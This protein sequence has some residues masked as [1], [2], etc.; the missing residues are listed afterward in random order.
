MKR[1]SLLLCFFVCATLCQAQSILGKWITYD[2]NTK[3]AAS[4]VEVTERSGKI[5]VQVKE[6]R[7][8][9]P[10]TPPSMK[11]VDCKGAK[12]DKPIVG[13][14][15]VEGAEKD[16]NEYK[17]IILDP[18]NGKE[19]KAKIWLDSENRNVLNVR[20]YIGPFFRTQVW[21]RGE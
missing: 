4:V 19:Y 21:K 13:M 11:C 18:A 12:K 9:P 1:I 17:G 7:N 10:N 15:I 8:P 6:M 3:L 5:F 16:G 20:G 14:Y 2:D